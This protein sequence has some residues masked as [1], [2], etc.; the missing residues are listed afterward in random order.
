MNKTKTVLAALLVT[1][2]SA[3]ATTAM[4]HDDDGHHGKRSHDYSQE[5]KHHGSKHHGEKRHDG[6]RHG[7]KHHG[8]KRHN[9]ERHG[10]KHHGEKRHGGKG[11][12]N[13]HQHGKRQGGEQMMRFMAKKLNMTDA[14]KMQIKELRT[15]QKAKMQPLREQSRTLRQEMM[16]LDT[17]SADYSTQVAALAD[18]KANI[19]RQSFILKSELRQQFNAVLTD[20]QRATMKSMQEKRQER[21]QKRMEKQE[22]K[23]AAKAEKTKAE[24]PA[25]AEADKETK[26]AE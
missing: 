15:A 2:M 17:T 8:E 21:M 25:P 6:E 23:K 1:A 16:K 11:H 9:G 26:A 3:G 12:G 5:G 18:K 14:Q 19:D 22:A 24:T 4:A 13:K 7:S 10:N 20:E